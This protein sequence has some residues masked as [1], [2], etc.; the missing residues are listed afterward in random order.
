LGWS[1]NKF[2]SVKFCNWKTFAGC[3]WIRDIQGWVLSSFYNADAKPWLWRISRHKVETYV[4]WWLI[5]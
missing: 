2:I 1:E 3:D 5:T 4:T